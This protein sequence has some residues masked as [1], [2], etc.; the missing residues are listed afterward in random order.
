MFR[1][2]QIPLT[3]CML[4]PLAARAEDQA[5]PGQNQQA[6]NHDADEKLAIA[7]AETWLARVDQEKY[8]ESWDSAAGLLKNAVGRDA[9]AKSLTAARKPLGPMKTRSVKAKEY[10]TSLPGAPDG[11]YVVIQFE[12]SL[13][14]K[15]S[16]IETVTPMLEPNGAW[17]VSGYY[18]R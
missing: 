10:H 2:L 12:T 15:K 11:K 18:I 13:E 1:F 8:G 17:K 4:I 7:A 9:F 6:A 14:H 5:N 16:A 3:L